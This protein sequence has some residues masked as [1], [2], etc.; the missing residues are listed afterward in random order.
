MKTKKIVVVGMGY[1]GFP[2]ACA[3]ASKSDFKV[4]GIDSDKEKVSKIKS[5]KSPVEDLPSKMLEGIDIKATNSFKDLSDSDFIIIC[6]PTPVYENKT[7]NLSFIIGT[8]ESIAKHLRKGQIII[9]ESTVNPG[10]CDEIIIP[11]LEKNGLKVGVDFDLIH[12]PERID[13]GNKKWNIYNIPR[14]IGGT[15]KKGL[16]KAISLYKTF[17]NAEIRELSSLKATEATK[18]IE[19]T[20]RDIN[21]AYVNELAKIFDLMNIDIIEIM[22]AA[23]TK[24]F[25]FI[26]HYPGC[27]VVGHC[28]P[29]DPYYL[30]QKSQDLGFNS[31]FMKRARLVNDSMPRYTIE[32]L[33]LGLNELGLPVKNTK[34]GILGLSYKANIGDLRESP[35]LEI[36]KILKDL[37]ADVLVCDPYVKNYKGLVNINYLLNNSNAVILATAHYE[38]LNILDWKK[39]KLIIDGRNCLN[40]EY[41]KNKKILYLGIGRK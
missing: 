23:S 20:F 29:V 17:L 37:H 21:I 4:V 40:K 8:A 24:P 35:S 22:N 27:G 1:V 2:L 5:K 39:V 26:P 11:I 19:N 15:S 28:I 31:E 12:C 9:L 7:P 10:V 30:I 16:Q 14:N 32:R 36:I 13:P 33:I 6:V 34:I 25:A 3:I 41:I 38:F 18:I